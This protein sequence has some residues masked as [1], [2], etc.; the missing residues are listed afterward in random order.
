[1]KKPYFIIFSDSEAEASTNEKERDELDS[2]IHKISVTNFFK[3]EIPYL[4]CDGDLVLQVNSDGDELVAENFEETLKLLKINPQL[5]LGF[6]YPD[7]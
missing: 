7:R 3:K 4:N 1:M 2:L 5:K 6:V